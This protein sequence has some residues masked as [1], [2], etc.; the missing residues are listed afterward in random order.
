MRDDGE[1]G[2]TEANDGIWTRVFQMPHIATTTPDGR[3]MGVR[4]GYKYTFGQSG[5]GWGGTEE[6][7]GNHRILELED[8]NGDGLIVRYDYFGDESSNKSKDNTNKGLCGTT[9]NPWPEEATPG[10]FQDS[11]ENQIDTDG[12]CLLDSYPQAP[13]V[14]TE[15]SEPHVPPIAQLT[16]ADYVAFAPSPS[17]TEV[18][19]AQVPNGG[20]NLMEVRGK[21]F[22]PNLFVDLQLRTAKTL[23]VAG[24]KVDGYWMPDSTRLHFMAPHFL[25]AEAEVVLLY[26]PEGTDNEA[27]EDALVTL[28]GTFSFEVAGTEGCSLAH[29][30]RMPDE[31]LDIPPGWVGEESYP[32]VGRLDHDGSPYPP[33][34]VDIALSPPCCREDEDCL[35]GYAPCTQ[36]P[37]PR[38]ESGWTFF[39][40]ELDPACSLPDGSGLD[41]CAAEG[42]IQF[43]GTIV[44]PLEKTRH[45]YVVRYSLDHGASWDFCDRPQAGGTFGNEDGFKLKNAGE[46]WVVGDE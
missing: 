28:A 9:R 16:G 37:D 34:L 12:D 24:I 18:L 2:D 44:P 20:G 41:T 21:N 15:C 30:A 46:L 25:A 17:L 19:P 6:W 39:P 27:T 32:V 3:R 36:L 45:R 29:P 40:M 1:G 22:S 35:Q 11:G 42:S 5:L 31:D 10:C 14:T 43:V 38:Y 4:L 13:L 26:F 33:L 7:P 23:E 8:A